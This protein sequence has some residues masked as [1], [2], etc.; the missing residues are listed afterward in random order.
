M[1]ARTLAGMADS[2]GPGRPP[3]QRGDPSVSVHVRVPSSQYD[4]LDQR[5]KAE[6][7]NIPELIRRRMADDDE[8]DDD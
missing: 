5:A 7:V 8:G 4:R 2:P 6:R 3:L 1:P